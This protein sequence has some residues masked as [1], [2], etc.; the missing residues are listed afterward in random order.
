MICCRN[1]SNRASPGARR[2]SYGRSPRSGPRRSAVRRVRWIVRARGEA[3]NPETKTASRGTP[4]S[5][6]RARLF[7]RR[8]LAR[9]S[10]GCG[11]GSGRRRCRRAFRAELRRLAG[12]DDRDRLDVAVL[13]LEDRHLG[14]LAVALLVELDVARRAVELDLGD[15]RE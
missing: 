9:R 11:C 10:R 13:H 15:L 12:L 3:G 8:F 7:L 5:S 6:M 4:F 1:M 2:E 14:V